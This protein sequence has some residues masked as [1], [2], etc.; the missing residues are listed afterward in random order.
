M[1][2]KKLQVFVSSTYT[3]LRA[4]RQ[5]AVEAILQA[6]HI[7]AGMELFASGSESQWET[8]CRWID[9]SDVFMLVLGARYGSIEPKSKKSYI[10]L[11]YEYA[12]QQKKPFFAAVISEKCVDAKT[13]TMGADAVERDNGHLLKPFRQA[14]TEKICRFFDDTKDIKIIVFESLARFAELENLHGWVRGDELIDAKDTLEELSRLR[15][16]NAA[17]AEE[18]AELRQAKNTH[19]TS[20]VPHISL[21]AKLLLLAAANADGRFMYLRFLGGAQISAG[22]QA[23][24]SGNDPREEARWRSAIQELLNEGLAE[25]RG[26]KNEVFGLTNRGFQVADEIKKTESGSA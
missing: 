6:G 25:D 13:K 9:D 20:V 3:D 16:S 2:Q 12:V 1:S 15:N 18:L 10:Q 7:P 23:V 17:L 11:E 14:V 5:A 26:Y 8:I 22:R 4:E 24:F 21:E 19:E